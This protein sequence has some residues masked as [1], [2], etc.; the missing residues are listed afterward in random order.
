M[1]TKK[2][3]FVGGLPDAP[4]DHHWVLSPVYEMK[5]TVRP[6]RPNDPEWRTALPSSFGYDDVREKVETE[7]VR[8]KDRWQLNL[9]RTDSDTAVR[10]ECLY[11][12]SDE[13][14]SVAAKELVTKFVSR[15]R[16][17]ALEEGP[18]IL[19]A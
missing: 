4:F 16:A 10:W 18:V 6:V 14:I 2:K 7:E 17:H 8:V 19:S 11:G 1:D 9:V 5:R 15:N 3:F 12:L 13:E